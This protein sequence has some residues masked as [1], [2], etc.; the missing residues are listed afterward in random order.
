LIRVHIEY[1][2]TEHLRGRP[3]FDVGCNS[4]GACRAFSNSL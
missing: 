2:I 1:N 3:G 4:W